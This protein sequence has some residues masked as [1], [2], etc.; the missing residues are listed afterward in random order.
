MEKHFS[1]IGKNRIYRFPAEKTVLIGESAGCDVKL[2]NYTDYEDC[3]IAKIAINRDGEGWH[4]VRIEREADL[5]VNGTGVNR[6]VYLHDGDR[7]EAGN[8]NFRFRIEKGEK[9]E[10]VVYNIKTSKSS[11]WMAGG[12]ILLLALLFGV[13][14]YIDKS[15]ALT[16]SQRNEIE[17]SLFAMRVDSLQLIHGD[18]II[19]SYVYAAGPVGTAFLTSD[20]LIVTARHCIQPWL[21]GVLPEDFS[22][23]PASSEWPVATALK[24]ETANQLSGI[25]D[26]KIISYVTLTDEAGNSFPLSSEA[27]KIN[28][29]FDDIV[30]M[31]SY[32]NPMYWRSIS[33][34]YTRSDLLL[35]DIAAAPFGRGGTIVTADETDL[36][37][38][39]DRKGIDL[40]FF[41][42][43]E[44]AVTGN[45]LEYKTD[46][47]RLP[48]SEL[49][50]LPGRLFLLS[51][52]GNLSPG[53]SG[54]P[55]IVRDGSGYRAVGVISVT[56][57]RNG[58][59]SY[60]VPV[61]ELKALKK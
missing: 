16:E 40:A 4:I 51:H 14:I 21:N 55:V 25:E 49:P 20:S 17:T 33:H 24:V 11:L 30:E 18:S 37:R 42:H 50:E 39:L 28:R 8:E 52:E 15:T 61:S 56:D 12:L 57:D 13:Y 31:G 59:R 36:R 19:E 22:S 6:V 45:K 2:P 38:L 9:S 43:P 48:L 35:G 54:G 34:R 10:P 60:S 27:F 7:I 58:Y 53:F 29:E 46:E 32:D 1:L 41:G 47:L 44:A 3:I 26:W 5:K 23:I